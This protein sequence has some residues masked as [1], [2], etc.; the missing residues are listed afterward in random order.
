MQKIK[1]LPFTEVQK[2]A[3]GQ[4]VE[5]PVNVVKEL[6]E[7][8]LDAGATKISIF[9][10]SAGQE[11]IRIVDNGCG[12]SPADAE[13]CFERHAT[14]KI[15]SFEQLSHLKT[16]GFRGEALYTIGA[17]SNV[18]LRTKEENNDGVCL[19]FNQGEL[20]KTEIVAA[21][22]GTDIVVEDLFC[23]VPARKKFL[24]K[25][26]TEW[27]LIVQLFQAFCLAYKEVH[28]QLYNAMNLVYNCP[29]VMSLIDRT[30]QLWDVSLAK[31]LIALQ[32]D[33]SLSTSFLQEGVISQ[34]HFFRYNR[35][36]IFFFVNKRW[37]TN[38][39]LTQA[40][41]KGYLNVLPPARYPVSIISLSIDPAEIDSNVH[42]RKEEVLFNNQ[43]QIEQLII[44][45]IKKTLE[46]KVTVA[47][48]P[49]IHDFSFSKNYESLTQPIIS[50][51]T[52]H[53]LK[54][55]PF[56]PFN[57]SNAFAEPFESLRESIVQPQMQ[58]TPS[59]LNK[60]P[61]HFDSVPA[62]TQQQ[63]IVVDE[64]PHFE[65]L[66]VLKKT[67][68]LLDHEDGIL[69]VDQHAA[70]ERILYEQYAGRFHEVASTVLLFPEIIHVSSA[71]MQLV[72]DNILLLHEYG[73]VC[74]QKGQN[75]LVIS[76]IPVHLKSVIWADF[77]REIIDLFIE[78]SHL[79]KD[80][81][82]TEVNKKMQAQM[83]C[84]AAVKAGD[85]L[86]DDQI[87]KLLQDLS[88]TE[89]RFSCPHGR[90]TSWV[91][92]LDEIEKKFKRKK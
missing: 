57:Y 52:A 51:S 42:P 28:F 21:E 41:L 27:R 15:V 73:I 49:A 31:N 70:H 32:P 12:M 6:V 19:I 60:S 40:L 92:P 16:F 75:Q 1:R 54:Q 33:N 30:A 90:P 17:V 65:I 88:K 59:F 58:E 18:T 61:E 48:E 47:L 13:L 77:I 76:A 23:N 7:N 85:E 80:Q 72:V 46:K 83:A 39:C 9:C 55:E 64:E 45:T 91:L 37:I 53:A 43:K 4:V 79:E 2:I 56:V 25:E 26:E 86:T 89:N 14:S 82:F 11:L 66:G 78:Y 81:F 44:T 68:I 34:H 87:K 84:K 3:A 22:I 71:D 5:R 20:K 8:S 50:P 63:H 67:Y 62:S 74:D 35:S 24:K 38:Y 29:P 10:K 36:N 69:F